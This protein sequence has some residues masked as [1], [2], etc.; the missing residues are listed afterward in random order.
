M[1]QSQ[2]VR[3]II[4]VHEMLLPSRFLR[5]NVNFAAS[6]PLPVKSTCRVARS[7]ARAYRVFCFFLTKLCS[8][9]V[10]MI[11]QS[12]CFGHARTR[13]SL[14]RNVCVGTPESVIRYVRLDGVQTVIEITLPTAST[15][16]RVRARQVGFQRRRLIGHNHVRDLNTRVR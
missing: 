10:A 11:M 5:E 2:S 1:L 3:R 16:R 7:R 14:S 8:K 13:L 6:D 4:R 15:V 9:D 12:T